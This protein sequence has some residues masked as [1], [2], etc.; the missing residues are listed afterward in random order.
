MD[1]DA[2]DDTAGIDKPQ[3]PSHLLTLC[4][5]SKDNPEAVK[6]ALQEADANVNI[7]GREKSSGQ[8]PLMAATLRGM[9]LTV[10]LLLESGADPTIGEK[11]GYTPAHGAGF[12]GQTAVMRVLKKYN[13]DLNDF[14]ADGNS[15]FHRAC[16]GRTERHAE[17]VRYMVED[18][19]VDV[20]LP[21]NEGQTCMQMTS[22]AMT[23]EVLRTLG[24]VETDAQEL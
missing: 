3:T 12:Q 10:E 4:M 1:N 13:L 24:A 18:G 7:N 6:E 14:H 23:K 17:L 21:S 16:W 15:P 9:A 11:Q 22:N 2:A 20:N 5:G 8:T 19:G